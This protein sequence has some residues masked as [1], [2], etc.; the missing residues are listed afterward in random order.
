MLSQMVANLKGLFRT[1]IYLELAQETV[2]IFPYGNFPGAIS[3]E[4]FPR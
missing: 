1:G 4:V 2:T 3:F